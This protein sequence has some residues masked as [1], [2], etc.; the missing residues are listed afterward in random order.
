VDDAIFSENNVTVYT[1]NGSLYVNSGEMVINS[2]LVYDIQGRLI[3]ERNN[4]KATAVTLD[5]LKAS[6]Q[7]LLVKVSGENNQV[8]TKKVVN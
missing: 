4:M 3:A 5:N 1:K 8:V 6:N 2:V 7:V